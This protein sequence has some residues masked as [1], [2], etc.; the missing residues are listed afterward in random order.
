MIEKKIV[1]TVRFKEEEIESID[2][3]LNEN[4]ALDFS[5]LIRL[6]VGKFISSPSLRSIE[7]KKIDT[8]KNSS[9]EISWN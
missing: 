5:T 9:E 1:K 4:P 8:G 2:S 7:K 3:F 6:A